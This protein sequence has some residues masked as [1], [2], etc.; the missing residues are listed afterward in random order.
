MCR[1]KQGD[2]VSTRNL[3]GEIGMEKVERVEQNRI[4]R[5]RCLEHCRLTRP[6]ADVLSARKRGSHNRLVHREVHE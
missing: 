5:R 2:F 6:V 1:F 3:E 4:V